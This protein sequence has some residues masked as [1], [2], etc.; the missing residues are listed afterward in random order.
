MKFQT[1]LLLLL[2]VTKIASAQRQS[3]PNYSSLVYNKEKVSTLKDRSIAIAIP[4][5]YD[6]FK[7]AFESSMK[8]LWKSSRYEF[9]NEKEAQVAIKDST[10]L[11]MGFYSV[12]ADRIEANGKSRIVHYFGLL[13]GNEYTD[14]Y[15][16][17]STDQIIAFRL[18]TQL[19]KEN[20]YTLR[21]ANVNGLS[22]VTDV[23]VRHFIEALLKMNKSQA[24]ASED[25]LVV[26]L[27]G[28]D[29]DGTNLRENIVV[30]ESIIA[31]KTILI[32]LYELSDDFN[33]NSFISKSTAR[34]ALYNVK[35]EKVESKEEMSRMLS[36]NEN[37]LYF[38][39]RDVNLLFPKLSSGSLY[40]VTSGVY[41][42]HITNSVFENQTP[43]KIIMGIGT[44]I[45]GAFLY[46]LS[47]L[48]LRWEGTFSSR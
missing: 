37:Y 38:H 3:N 36:T 42:G 21:P 23:I 7:T 47:N 12:K 5:E 29:K 24:I 41:A 39:Q 6:E 16:D 28:K 26:K 8:K 22:P 27:F 46:V 1:F 11:V 35:I 4:A 18:N 2:F 30:D 48:T 33:V 43:F 19:E 17:N 10:K 13:C 25:D 44:G 14:R 34:L 15:Q 20:V 9:V 45:G 32:P 31:S 40:D